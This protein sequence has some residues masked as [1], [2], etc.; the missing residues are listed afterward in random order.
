MSSLLDR[1][2]QEIESLGRKAQAALDEGKLQLELLRFRR[3]REEAASKLG[4]LVHRRERN[5]E[6]DALEFDAL[7]VR[8]DG[9]D[10]DIARIERA[11]AALKG[12]R[13]SVSQQP[14]PAAT[15]RAEAEIV[16]KS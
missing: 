1:L 7:L 11:V 13:V 6:V 12:E 8:L 14:A 3:E 2:S 9:L 4:L 16:E 15:E 5:G 10:V